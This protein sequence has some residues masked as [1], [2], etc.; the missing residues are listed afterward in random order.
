M[1]RPWEH[2]DRAGVLTSPPP[3]RARAKGIFIRPARD[4]PIFVS[5]LVTAEAS[6]FG[7]HSARRGLLPPPIPLAYLAV[8]RRGTP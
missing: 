6:P 8:G 2:R 7:I 4:R 1:S 3:A 5:L